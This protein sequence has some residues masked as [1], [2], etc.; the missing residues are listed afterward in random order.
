M[1]DLVFPDMRDALQAQS[2]VPVVVIDDADK[3][4]PLAEALVEGGLPVIEV[5]MRTDAALEAISNIARQVPGAIVGAGTVLSAKHV[6]QAK[7]AG[8]KFAVSPGLH[9]DVVEACRSSGLPIFPGV[10]SAGE[11]QAAWNMGLRALKFFPA[12]QAGGLAMLKAL[13]A[14]FR[15]VVFMPTGGVSPANLGDYL[16][17]P[18]VVAVGGSWLTPADLIEQGDFA[19]IRDLAI[20]ASALASGRAKRQKQA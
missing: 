17:L 18:S 12:E 19:A 5:T 10:A 8:S 4:V 1:T 20:E 2:V 6:Q 11:A 14:V 3:A 15:D 7:D 16:S 9:A 13:S